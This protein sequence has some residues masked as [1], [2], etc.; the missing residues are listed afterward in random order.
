MQFNYLEWKLVLNKCLFLLKASLKLYE[1][2]TENLFLNLLSFI[3]RII[4]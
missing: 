1:K 4:I 2:I 3:F